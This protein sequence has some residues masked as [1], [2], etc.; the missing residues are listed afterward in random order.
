MGDLFW[1]RAVLAA[2]SPLVAAFVG[3]LGIG[4]FAAWITERIQLR[5][6]DRSLREQIVVGMTQTASAIYIETQRY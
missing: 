4:L 5:R 6:Q 3:T 2:I 1:Q